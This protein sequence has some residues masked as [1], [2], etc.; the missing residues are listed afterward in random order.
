VF[1]V[2]KGMRMQYIT[3]DMVEQM[4]KENLITE[5]EYKKW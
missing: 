5:E 4:R 1:A 3:D 2:K